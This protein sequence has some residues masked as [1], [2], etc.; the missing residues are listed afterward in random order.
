MLC[1]LPFP[2]VLSVQMCDMMQEIELER[3][4]CENSTG[5]LTAGEWLFVGEEESVQ[6]RRKAALLGAGVG[7]PKLKEPY[8]PKTPKSIPVWS[9][10]R[11]KALIW[12]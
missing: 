9:R 1:R 7:N 8:W 11:L 5:N 4:R 6:S 2:Q 10:K 12:A 3:E